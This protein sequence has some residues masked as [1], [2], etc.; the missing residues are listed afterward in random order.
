MP[1]LASDNLDEKSFVT[2]EY[3]VGESKETKNSCKKIRHR[4][5]VHPGPKGLPITTI[6]TRIIIPQS[7]KFKHTAN[8]LHNE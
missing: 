3:T 2:T 1:G 4:R 5:G 8:S 6:P 7:F